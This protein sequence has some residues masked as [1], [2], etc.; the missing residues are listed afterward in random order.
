MES[1][2]GPMVTI[3][4][5]FLP[6]E[7]LRRLAGCE[8]LSQVRDLQMTVDTSEQTLGDLGL[9]LPKLE[10]LRLSNSNV[11]TLRDLGSAMSSLRILWLARS[12]L[13]ELEGVGAFAMLTEL[14]VAFNGITDL[15]P[16]MNT[17]RLQVSSD[18][19]T[20]LC[21][22]RRGACDACAI[23]SR[24]ALDSRAT[25]HANAGPGSGGKCNCGPGT[26]ELLPPP[27]LAHAQC[28]AWS[29]SSIHSHHYMKYHPSNRHSSIQCRTATVCIPIV[30]P[31][32]LA[33]RLVGRCTICA[34]AV[35][36][37]R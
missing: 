28:T 26:G 5:E 11:E 7:R 32:S 34:V 24:L 14:Y 31:Y 37:K 19:L 13:Q 33:A 30:P 36:Y 6:D 27:L 29:T 20:P 22:A 2:D 18:S 16:L 12:C 21:G 10:E 35:T 3:A 4:E 1:L 8:N 23:L 25:T 15:S 9:R 17:E